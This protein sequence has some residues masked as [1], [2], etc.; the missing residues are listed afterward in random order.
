MAA[1]ALATGLFMALLGVLIS[2]PALVRGPYLQL[3]TPE[4]VTIVWETDVPVVC[5]LEIGPAGG[6]ATVIAGATGTV[7]AIDVESLSRGTL[8]AYTPLADG[9]PLDAP[10]VFR[11]DDPSR[12]FSFLVVGDSGSG[13]S[14]QADVRD[15]MEATPADFI[16]H[17]GDMVY[18]DGAAEDF[19]PHFFRPYR[20]LVRRLVFWPCLGNHDVR[21]AGGAPWRDAFHTPANNPAGTENYYSF[22]F[23]NAHVVVLNSNADLAAG[24]AQHTFLDRDLAASVATWKFVAF[25]HSIYSSRRD[26][27][28]LK[29]ALVPVFDRHR[30]DAVFMGHDHHYERTHLLRADQVVGPG[31]GTLYVTTGARPATARN[32]APPNAAASRA[33]LPATTGSPAPSICATTRP[34]PARTAPTTGAART[35]TPATVRSDAT[36]P[37]AAS[38]ERRRPIRRAPKR[39]SRSSKPTSPCARATPPSISARRRSCG[40]TRTP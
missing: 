2:G 8:Y 30:V 38:R 15:A 27:P 6:A 5:G 32:A 24:S 31:E 9:A 11:T 22:D 3:L 12:P 23:G 14:K 10:S 34:A 37:R 1:A 21:T 19:D 4:S 26:Y 36:P 28:D 39:P 35:R 17:T 20:D 18:D 40:R 16:L 33:W 25:H 7:C 13:G 29:A